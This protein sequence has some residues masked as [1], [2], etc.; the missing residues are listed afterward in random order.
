M[1]RTRKHSSKLVIILLSAILLLLVAVRLY[2]FNN[3]I[4]DWHSWR[5]TDTSAVSRSFVQNG[6][7]LLHPQY[8]DISNIQSG[9]DNP[10]GYRFVE[11]PIYNILQAVGFQVFDF[12]TLEQWGRIITIGASLISAVFLF[13]LLRKFIDPYT[14][15]VGAFLFAV[16]PYSIYYGRSI[17][18]D[19]MMAACVL[20]SIYFFSEWIDYI[21]TNKQWL[22]FVLSLFFAILSLLLKPYA[23]FFFIPM[24]YL[25]FQKWRFK[26][27]TQPWLWIFLISAVIPL[28]VWR[29]WMMQYPEG[30][31][32]NSW[33]FNAGNI[34]FKGAF[35]YW[36]FGERIAKLILGY[37]GVVFLLLGM[38]KAKDDK[39]Y[40][41]FITFLISSFLYVS[42]IARGNVQHDYYQILIIPTLVLFAARGVRFIYSYSQTTNK[43]SG[44]LIIGVS[45]ILMLSLSWYYVRDYFNINNPALV[46][47]GKK[48][49]DILPKNAK[50]IAPLDG[51]TTLLYYINRK[52]WPAF[53]A[54][55]EDLMK[56]G[57]SYVVLLH[58][59]EQ[60]RQDWSKK[61]QIIVSNSDYI[62]VKL[63]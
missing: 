31:P 16:L 11:F 27:L 19:E 12:F 49:D 46:E 52:G 41:F 9:K 15:L 57:A 39:N 26:M 30:I 18:P 47:A 40:G 54:S 10:N 13:L 4:A 6:Y 33:L 56:K 50:V 36:I 37:F 3:P 5:Q 23:I 22:Y 60:D 53:Q 2:R 14:G 35:F 63:Q 48:A 34:R 55:T 38:L 29:Y 59:S 58:P 45:T 7:D 61:Y 51:D 8:N 28:A 24:V 62:I 25:A 20:V 32:A 17:L 21:G 1:K 43:L 44:G 42:V